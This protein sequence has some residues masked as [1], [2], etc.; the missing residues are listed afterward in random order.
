MKRNS[1]IIRKSVAVFCYGLFLAACLCASAQPSRA[2]AI[3]DWTTR[4]SMPT[5]RIGAASGVVNGRI[6]VLGGSNRLN[7]PPAGTMATVEAYDSSTDTWSTLPD[8]IVP[9]FAAA[10]A[11]LGDTVYVAGGT[12]VGGPPFGPNYKNTVVAYNAVTGASSIIG[13]LQVARYRADGDIINNKLY[14]A[15][16]RGGIGSAVLSSIEE[17]DL[18]VNSSV[19][20]A[21]L[22]MP[23]DNPAAAAYSG[24]LYILGGFNASGTPLNTCL[25]Y[26]PVTNTIAAKSPMPLARGG[27][28]AIVINNKI[29]L[30]G[31]AITAGPPPITTFSDIQEYDPATDTWQIVGMLPTARWGVALEVINSTVFIIGG[32]DNQQMLTLNEA[33]RFDTD[34]NIGDWMT[35]E[36]MPTARS[37]AASGVVNGKIFVLGGSN[38]LNPPPAGTMATVEAYDPLTGMWTTMAPLIEPRFAGGD[39]TVGDNIYIAGGTAVGGPPYGSNYQNTVVAYNTVTGLS[40]IIGYL[41][42]A[43]FRTDADVINNKLY[44]AGGRGG[45]GSELLDSIEEYD[46]ASNTSMLKANLPAPVDKPAAIAYNG[47]LYI[48]GGFDANGDPV[49]TCLEYDPETNIITAKSPM[50]L[51]R[52]GK[53]AVIFNNM[54]YLLGGSV[55]AGPPPITTFS[56]IQEYD[57]ATDAWRTAGTLPTVRWGF[58]S[59]TINNTVFIIGGSDNEQALGLNEMGAFN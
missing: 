52:G 17:Y 35:G 53:G 43:R 4:Q 50:P 1:F 48:L 31:G 46:L 41:Q 58:V 47:K 27:D 45:S 36:P 42:V 9:R 20:K 34:K 11:S 26:N 18:A 44:V 55:T 7:P 40:S 13:Y 19:V 28:G 5:A 25:E 32:S 38:T 21:M 15:G 14:V 24:K 29:Y 59:E 37:G 54:I 56:D 39:A 16:G 10:A 49:N 51:A 23:T 57:P 6:I 3:T 12:A 2:D 22:P 8:M 33:G 30:F